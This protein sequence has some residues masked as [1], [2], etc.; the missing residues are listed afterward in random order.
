[1]LDFTIGACT[2]GQQSWLFRGVCFLKT[3][4]A[5]GVALGFPFSSRL[6]P[7]IQGTRTQPPHCRSA[8]RVPITKPPPKAEATSPVPPPTPFLFTSRPCY[9]C[10]GQVSSHPTTSATARSL[11]CLAFVCLVSCALLS[12]S[13]P[14]LSCRSRHRRLRRARMHLPRP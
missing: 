3:L 6:P 12:V 5:C 8:Y 2:F 14:L 11:A 4:A 1:M 10:S 7:K 9:C 13:L